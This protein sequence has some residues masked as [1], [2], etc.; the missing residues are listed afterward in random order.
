MQV[1]RIISLFGPLFRLDYISCV[2][3]IVSTVLLGRRYWQGWIIAGANSVLICVIALRTAQTG[4]IAANV[5]CVLIYGYNV[6]K[7]RSEGEFSGQRVNE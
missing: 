4:F 5:F 1:P 7:W 2:L 6:M 3:T